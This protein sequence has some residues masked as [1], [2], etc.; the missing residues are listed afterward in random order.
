[1]SNLIISLSL[2]SLLLS[3]CTV[4]PYTQEAKAQA[5]DE[6]LYIKARITKEDLMNADF[7]E[8]L[9]ADIE[10][11]EQARAK[12]P[13]KKAERVMISIDVDKTAQ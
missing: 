10:A 4:N 12:H 3:G 7:L 2:V 6:T 1:M 8:A 5:S 11:M 9:L 13:N